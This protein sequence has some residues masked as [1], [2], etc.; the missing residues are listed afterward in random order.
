MR[1][2]RGKSRIGRKR[3]EDHYINSFTNYNKLKFVKAL[4]QR[5]CTASVL[6]GQN[7]TICQATIGAAFDG[8]NARTFCKKK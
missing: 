8:L 4:N 2:I 5:L 6:W 7:G 3:D 1:E